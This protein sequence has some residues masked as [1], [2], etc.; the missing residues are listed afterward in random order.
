LEELE[1]ESPDAFIAMV[2]VGSSAGE[3]ED[4]VVLVSLKNSE[5]HALIQLNDKFE[6]ETGKLRIRALMV[7]QNFTSRGFIRVGR[8]NG[9]WLFEF[10]DFQ[11]DSDAGRHNGEWLFKSLDFPPGRDDW[12]FLLAVSYEIKSQLKAPCLLSF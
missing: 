3:D 11:P 5:L 8:H 2:L 6:M 9:G 7:E 12:D 4:K 10:P 1:K